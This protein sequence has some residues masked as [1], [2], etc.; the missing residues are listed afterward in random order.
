MPKTSSMKQTQAGDTVRV[1]I[2]EM[3]PH[4][5]VDGV[6]ATFLSVQNTKIMFHVVTDTADGDAVEVRQVTHAMVIPTVT[7]LEFLL[8]MRNQMLK[9]EDLFDAANAKM[10]AQLKGYVRDLAEPV[11][12]TTESNKPKRPRK[13]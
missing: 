6:S 10:I 5:F 11:T 3:L 2:P 9:S 1:E 12:K 7:F 13:H 8:N 4:T